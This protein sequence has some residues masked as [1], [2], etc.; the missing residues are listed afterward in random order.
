[1]TT[2]VQTGTGVHVGAGDGVLVGSGVQ[3]GAGVHVGAT[4][5]D[6][7][8]AN[9]TTNAA[10]RATQTVAMVLMT[11]MARMIKVLLGPIVEH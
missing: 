3:V 10:S 8:Q 6:C 7:V 2:G 9:E 4:V 5:A 11:D 1:M